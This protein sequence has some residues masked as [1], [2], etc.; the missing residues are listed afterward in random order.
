MTSISDFLPLLRQS[1]FAPQYTK[2]SAPGIKVKL[3]PRA[4]PQNAPDAL[5]VLYQMEQNAHFPHKSNEL[6]G[7]PESVAPSKK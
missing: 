2:K 5:L 7:E 6:P 4:L 1:K 3:V